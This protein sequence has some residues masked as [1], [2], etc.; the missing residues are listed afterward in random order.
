MCISPIHTRRDWA[1]TQ[2]QARERGG[3]IKLLLSTRNRTLTTRY[4]AGAGAAAAPI[5]GLFGAF[6]AAHVCARFQINR[7]LTSVEYVYIYILGTFAFVTASSHSKR[8]SKC[9]IVSIRK[10]T[11][12]PTGGDL[13]TRKF[14]IVCLF[15]WF[16]IYIWKIAIKQI[17]SFP[18]SLY[19]RIDT[20]SK[21]VIG[22]IATEKRE[23]Q[24]A[25]QCE[26]NA[27][28]EYCFY[29][30]TYFTQRTLQNFPRE[31]ILD[32]FRGSKRNS[33]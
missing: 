31:G 26:L 7:A 30:Y 6:Q 29:I 15:D 1:R 27:R 33:Q 10:H 11:L 32:T 8:S 2:K 4:V 5:Y 23:Q 13:L 17:S 14:G 19:T 24:K 16:S 18:V 9:I 12:A 20:I 25:F 21:E 3:Q 28:K 22:R